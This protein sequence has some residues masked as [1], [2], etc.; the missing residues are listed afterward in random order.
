MGIVSSSRGEGQAGDA[1]Q[2]HWILVEEGFE[3]AREHE[4]E[5][6]FTVANGYLGT[7]GSLQEGTSLSLPATF[8]AGVFNRPPDSIRELVVA[9]DWAKFRIFVEGEELRLDRGKTL[10][11]RRRLDMRRG[12]LEREWRHSDAAGRITR[13][14]F[15]RFVSLADRHALVESV[16]LTPEN[17]SARVSVEC[18]IDGRVTNAPDVK[19]LEPVE[20]APVPLRP[21]AEAPAHGVRALPLLAACTLE[22][23]VIL[24]FAFASVL[25][26]GEVRSAEHAMLGGTEWLGERWAWDA[27][28]GLSYR[29]DK[30]VAAYTS[31][32]GPAPGR[33]AAEHLSRLL[34]SGKDALLEEHSK[35][36]TE[37]WAAADIEIEGDEE[38]QRA[39]RLGIYHLI[40]SANPEDERVSVGARALTG[41]SY[42]GHVFWDTEI[43]MLPFYVFTH[44]PS[45]RAP[46]MYRYHTLPEARKK[47]RAMGYRGALYPWESTDTG[48]EATPRLVMTPGGQ[49]IPILTGDQAHHISA[50]VAYAAWQYWRATGDDRFLLQA[51]AEIMLETARF[52]TS[53]AKL[54][55]DG[56]YHIR[57]VIGPDEYHE[58]V[59]DNAYTNG[60]AR[61]NLERGVETAQLLRKRWPER[62]AELVGRLGL[63]ASEP[64]EWFAVAHG[65]Y[66]GFDPATALFEQFQGYFDLEYVDLSTYEPRTAPIDILL[67]RERTA[68]TQIIKQPDVVLLT[69]LL[70]DQFPAKVHEANFRYYEPRCGHGSSLSPS[71]HALVAARLGDRDLATRYF[72]QAA[73][74]DL[75][76]NMGNAAGGVHAGALGGLWQSAV[77]G[78][79]GMRL[80]DDGLGLDPHLLPQWQSL[81]FPVQWRGRQVRVAT[82]AAPQM[83]EVQLERGEPIAVALG[84]ADGPRAIVEKAKRYHAESAAGVW[85]HWKEVP[86]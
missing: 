75:A 41:E 60:M 76:D 31:R 45:A 62:W 86:Q 48:E 47:A 85:R 64:E 38:G 16:T 26:L 51:G 74:I 9:P 66:T 63:A 17:Y 54:E 53:R 23:G 46:L 79:A 73:E 81:I 30:L 34:T 52:W 28:I 19:H 69:Y 84:K 80:R 14:H 8:V 68:Q 65:M 77:F 40:A 37:R 7:R 36:W 12:L 3:P 33:L 15:I 70:W 32:D 24:A 27:Q 78:L 44:P 55:G 59:D 2:Q 50:A 13:L 20:M 29:V 42:K 11:H 58:E 5:S 56:R 72:R 43:Y 10:E 18:I 1:S 49:L 6:L 35:A 21:D 57:K 61:W 83:I 39:V 22:S 4:I 25:G 82:S 67:G 71:I